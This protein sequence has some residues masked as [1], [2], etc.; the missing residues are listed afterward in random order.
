MK[1]LGEQMMKNKYYTVV[2]RFLVFLTLLTIAFPSISSADSLIIDHNCTDISQIPDYWL[3]QAKQLTLHYGHTSHGSQINSGLEYLESLDAK[4]SVAIRTD[5]TAGLPPA[6]DPPALRIY[7]GNPPEIYI[8]PEDYWDGESALNRTRA[9]LDTGDYDVS[10]FSWCTQL[11]YYSESKLNEYLSALDLLESEYPNVRFIY[12]TQHL[13]SSNDQS[14]IYYDTYRQIV[15]DRNEQIRSFCRD[16]NKILYDFGDIEA[17]TDGSS[18]PCTTNAYHD[19]YLGIPVE[20]DWE[21]GPPTCAHSCGPN[22]IRK[23]KAFWWMMARLAGWNNNGEYIDHDDDGHTELDNCPCTY[24]PEQE[25]SDGDGCGDACDGR[26]DNPN[27][28]STYGSILYGETH[29]C[30]MVLANGQYV[31]TCGQETGL[32]DLEVPLD[33]NTGE[34]TFQVFASGFSPF[35]KAFTPSQALCNDI[36]MAR[37]NAGSREMIIDFQTEP[38]TDNPNWIRIWGTVT[39]N[40][41]DVCAMVLANGQRMFSCPPDHSGVFDLEVPLDPNNDEITL[42]VFAT[43]FAPYKEIFIP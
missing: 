27:W 13:G 14:Y 11:M 28:V 34:I 16:N 19:Y 25:D 41:Q 35:R 8:N 10:M 38:G 20:C 21:D 5:T 30:T 18:T 36:V 4:Y 17:Y 23:G 32:Y 12:M 22:C 43:G 6:E 40:G 42:Q 39:H 3:E 29:L 9:V 7:D 33:P 26:P 24:N 1:G 15:H 2:F 37:P 31:F